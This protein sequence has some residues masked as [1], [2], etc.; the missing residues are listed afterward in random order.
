MFVLPDAHPGA[1]AEEDALLSAIG[2]LV[3]AWGRMEGDLDRKIMA[4]RATAGDVRIVGSRT[5]PAMSR[6]FAELRAI[7]SMRDK[8]GATAL[9]EIAE[10]ERAVQRLDRFR[11]LVIEGF[12]AVEGDGFLV[13]D[14]KNMPIHISAE[15]LARDTA[16]LESLS[17]RLMAL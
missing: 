13:R 17:D 16:E 7:V 8:R 14:G 5:R 15:H 6:M 10:V 12:T 11:M 3:C 9:T 4:M 2:R 1:S